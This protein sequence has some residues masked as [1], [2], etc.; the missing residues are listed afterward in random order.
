VTQWNLQ[1]ALFAHLSADA[2]LKEEIGDPARIFDD[3]PPDAAFPFVVIGESRSEGVAGADDL[4]AH[5][6]RLAVHSHYAGRKDVK[7]VLDR[8]YDALNDADFAIDG[9]RLVSLRFIFSDVFRRDADTFSGVARFRA[10]T[11]KAS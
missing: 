7:R 2:G 3:P 6:V 9:A 10:V 5:D 11:E 4:L 8:L 1:R